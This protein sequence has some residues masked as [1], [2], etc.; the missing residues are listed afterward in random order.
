MIAAVAAEIR[1]GWLG[2]RVERA[3]QPVFHDVYLGLYGSRRTACLI[4][5]AHPD[6]D[7]VHLATT[8]PAN[9]RTPLGFCQALRRH[10]EGSRLLDCTQ[11]GLERALDL[12]FEGRDELGNPRVLHLIAE[13][14]GRLANLV[15]TG[16][17]GRVIEALRRVDAEVNRQR[18]T[19]PGLPYAAPPRSPGKV[20]PV[21]ALGGASVAGLVTELQAAWADR[22]PDEPA[23]ER[24]LATVFGVSR[25]LAQALAAWASGTAGAPP[26]PC[27][28][29]PQTTPLAASVAA[30]AASVLDGAFRP[31]VAVD[32]RGGPRPLAWPLPGAAAVE[33]ATASLAC[34]QA[35]ALA[36]EVRRGEAFRQRLG[37]AVRAARE[38]VSRRLGKQGAELAAARDADTLRE[39]GELLLAYPH[40]VPRGAAHVE[41][42]SFTDPERRVAIDLDPRLPAVPNAQ[43]LLRRYQKER[44]A[45]ALVAVRV[46]AGEGELAYL[47][48][49]AL[50]LAQ[51]EG[52]SELEALEAELTAQGL[53]AGARRGHPR[54]GGAPPPQRGRRRSG[55]APAA[56]PA[57]RAEPAPPLVFVGAAGWRILVGRNAGG[58]DHL[59]MRLAR[60][61]DLWL[62]AKQ[63]P[64]SHVLLRAPAEG[65][66]GDPPEEALLEAARC[67]A[68]YS[69]GRAGRRIPVDY[70]R[71]RHVWK[72]G[73]ARPGFV[74]Y[75]GERTVLADPVDLPAREGDPPTR[76]A[77]AD[78][79]AGAPQRG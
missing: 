17:D 47:E 36:G 48:E 75:Q 3:G 64:G 33:Y 19:L 77:W 68:Y 69:A 27:G 53:L 52:N 46:A 16:P 15:L 50:A 22:P 28:L 12:R 35:Y 76:S 9:A 21:L 43:R 62:H 51:A 42:P 23:E 7:R 63:M 11:P 45:A 37:A 61:D 79:S 25:A 14:T 32:G 31:C 44:R 26:W 66:G 58:N 60:P 39:A 13:L 65:P 5:S 38:R 18:Q 24:L 56:A 78:P 6:L 70:T 59:T 49:A 54:P 71:R 67:A 73:G 40:L 1:S 41:L 4:L 72:P 29:P 2:A 20:D 10:L 55:R 74:L 34:A 57:Q 30:M 8:R